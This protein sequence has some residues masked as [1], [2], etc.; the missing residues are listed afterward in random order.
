[1]H[2]NNNCQQACGRHRVGEK[3]GAASEDVSEQNDRLLIPAHVSGREHDPMQLR[4]Q[5]VPALTPPTKLAE[6][7]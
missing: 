3:V 7:R 5:G 2:Q 4:A 1:M 6:L